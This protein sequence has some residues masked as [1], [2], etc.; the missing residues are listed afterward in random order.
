MKISASNPLIHRISPSLNKMVRVRELLFRTSSFPFLH[1][2]LEDSPPAVLH[3]TIPYTE[4]LGGHLA[5]KDLMKSSW[6]VLSTFKKLL[7]WLCKWPSKVLNENTWTHV[8]LREPKEIQFEKGRKGSRKKT[9][10][11]T[12]SDKGKL[13]SYETNRWIFILICVNFEL[14]KL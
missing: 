6:E 2:Y 3:L 12:L 10:K 8:L 5:N 14:F 7:W 13:V 11:P 1:L 9:S 4:R